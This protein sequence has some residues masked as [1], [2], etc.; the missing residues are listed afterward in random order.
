MLTDST[1]GGGELSIHVTHTDMGLCFRAHLN[2]RK[3]DLSV[4]CTS[5]WG[6]VWTS[7]EVRDTS[8]LK[9]KKKK[10]FFNNEVSFFSSK[11]T[12]RLSCILNAMLESHETSTD[13]Y[14]ITAR[15]AKRLGA[16]LIRVLNLGFLIHNLIFFLFFAFLFIFFG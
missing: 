15:L 5:P 3:K 1:S 9:K 2:T 8:K 13:W 16:W 10:T 4:G 7:P 6:L 11:K 14:C 12:K